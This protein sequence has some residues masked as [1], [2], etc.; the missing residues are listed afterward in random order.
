MLKLG[1]LKI[2]NLFSTQV[3]ESNRIDQIFRSNLQILQRF[4]I[5]KEFD[6]L[7][8]LFHVSNANGH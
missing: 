2:W 6:K 5:Y 3:N 4:I 1:M 7:K 8:L